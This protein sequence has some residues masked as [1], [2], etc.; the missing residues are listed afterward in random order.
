MLLL[1]WASSTMS[2][3]CVC[4]YPFGETLKKSNRHLGCWRNKQCELKPNNALKQSK[5]GVQAVRLWIHLAASK[6]DMWA[7]F[8]RRGSIQFVR[9][10]SYIYIYI[11]G[12]KNTMNRT[13]PDKRLRD[14]RIRHKRLAIYLLKS[15]HWHV[16]QERP[17][18]LRL[19]ECHRRI[20]M[21]FSLMGDPFWMGNTIEPYW[22]ILK[23][24][25]PWSEDFL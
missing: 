7:F 1:V 8:G 20:N 14:L 13:S 22:T 16:C 17:I 5:C 12:K 3:H 18:C 21:L 11:F 6:F 23:H 10:I 24:I 15:F 2:V 9:Y 4:D 25:E 19:F